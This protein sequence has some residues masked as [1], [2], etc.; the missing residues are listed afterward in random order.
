MASGG[1]VLG[2]V[3]THTLKK[4]NVFCARENTPVWMLCIACN[5]GDAFNASSPRSA[6]MLQSQQDGRRRKYEY[7]WRERWADLCC[8]SVC[9]ALIF[10]LQGQSPPPPA[11]LMLMLM[12]AS[13]AGTLTH[14]RRAVLNVYHAMWPQTD[15]IGDMGVRLLVG[16]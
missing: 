1:C 5:G 2:S 6:W 13:Q 11:V 12:P 4:K 7:E 16:V 8:V 9:S 15:S 14:V 10:S 3:C